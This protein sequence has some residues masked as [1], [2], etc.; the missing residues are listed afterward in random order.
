[1]LSMIYSGPTLTGSNQEG[2]NCVSLTEH[3]KRRAVYVSGRLWDVI[4]RTWFCQ[5]RDR[6]VDWP[7]CRM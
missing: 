4:I 7:R 2:F 1:M 6:H 5:K 3:Q